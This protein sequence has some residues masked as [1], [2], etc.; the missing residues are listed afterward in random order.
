MLIVLYPRVVI[1]FPEKHA[2]E[3]NKVNMQE[4]EI[5]YLKPPCP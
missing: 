5:Y 3:S 4:S 1:F 2:A